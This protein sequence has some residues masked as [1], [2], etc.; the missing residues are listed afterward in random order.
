MT[1]LSRVRKLLWRLFSFLPVTFI[2]LFGALFYFLSTL[3]GL[4]G[5]GAWAMFQVGLPVLGLLTFLATLIYAAM[6]RRWRSPIVLFTLG[7]SFLAALTVVWMLGMVPI[8]YPVAIDQVQPGVAVRLP[9]D[10]PLLVFW[11]GDTLSTN[12]H[13]ASPDQRWAYDL[14][15]APSDLGSPGLEDY[16]CYGVE[17]VAPADGVVTKARDGVPDEVP[18]LDAENLEQPFGNVVAIRLDET[19]THLVLAHLKPGSVTVTEG[20]HVTEGQ[21]VGQCGNSG[22]STEPHIHIHH[23]RQDADEDLMGRAEGLPLYFRDHDGK[24]MP[25]GGYEVRD[26]QYVSLGDTVTHV[27]KAGQ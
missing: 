21:V 22:N 23:Q 6:R 20:E 16:G 13:V 19:G 10:A 9:A 26:G 11:G 8:K 3:G 25:T 4:D 15:V 17:V 5:A 18:S 24:P 7:T 2:V 1:Q 12:Y 27:P 14:G